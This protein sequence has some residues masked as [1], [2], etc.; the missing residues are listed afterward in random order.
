MTN[1]T[2]VQER[3]REGFGVVTGEGAPRRL[4]EPTRAL[5]ARYLSGEFGQA[6]RAADFRLDEAAATSLTANMLYAQTV[7]LI[8]QNAPLRILPQERLVGAATLIEAA[9]HRLPASDMGSTSHTTIGFERVLAGGYRALRAQIAARRARGG[10]DEAGADLLDAMELCLDAAA[11]WHRRH[12]DRLAEL[13]ADSGGA[14]REHFAA[15]RDTL[16]G[17]PENSPADFRQAVQSLWFMWEF[18]RLCGNWSGL[19]RVDAMLGP[20]L[21][22]D[23]AAGRITLD[24][25]REFIARFWIKGC[26][27]IDGRGRGSGD[28]QF[29]QNVILAG[30]DAH[31]NEVAN[32][33]TWL[34]LDVVESLH[35]SD[36]PIAVRVSNRTPERLWRRIA[37][38]QRFGGGIV[39]LYNEDLV[40]RALTRAG[41]PQADAR[42]FTNDGCWEV[43][44]PG[45][46]AFTYCPFD[47]LQTLQGAMGL[48]ADRPGED[49]GDFE[50]LY[51]AFR[52]R[53]AG[54]V[55]QIID[56]TAGAFRSGPPAPLLSLFVDDCIER[57]RGYH[58]RGA[59]YSV[60]AVHAGGLP[61]A[62]NSLYAID[63]IVYR[64]HER[65][66]GQMVDI[67]RRD[68]A[69]EEAL[70]QSIEKRLVLYGNDN[71][72]ADAM[73]R[74]VFDDFVAIVAAG[75]RDD[76]VA[77]PAGISTFGREIGWR[78]GRFATAFG[79]HKGDILA[80]NM[81]PT[82]G[83]DTSGPTAVV[84][85]YCSMDFEKLTNG[86]PLELKFLP[87]TLSGQSGLAALVALLKTFVRLGGWYL[88]VD[89]VDSQLLRDAQRHPERYPNLVVRISGWSAR[90][91]TL[92]KEW[93]DMIIN[94]T[95]Q[96]AR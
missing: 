88:Q 53:L 34:V 85:S 19:G 82:P 52:A 92:S 8:A 20:Y 49:F 79:R 43:L 65:T 36:F 9:Q 32:D 70:R 13:A 94:R 78:D 90:F 14:Q 62:A 63:K 73:V 69:G 95:E 21:A 24:E 71:P 28:A 40:V 50:S 67:L 41:Y 17:V 86:T 30:V 57:A 4:S 61:D 25:A 58:D 87:A 15:L 10:L 89:S 16:A 33:V 81:A 42:T 96:A 77:H 27:W 68:W 31:G 76:G 7:M 80:T 48:A 46:T 5:A 3:L 47:V 37:E 12:M 75:R 1:L 38:V 39:S 44:I 59:R 66:L 55:G 45:K 54:E 26:E 29:Y 64:E 2:S 72:E 6:M 60:A 93:Q 11:V 22:R 83:T 23:L 56:G 51:A 74:R 91:A 35:I 84:K 18:Q